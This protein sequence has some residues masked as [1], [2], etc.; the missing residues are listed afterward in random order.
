LLPVS[1]D[2]DSNDFD[3]IAASLRADMTDLDA[4]FE[5]LAAKLE[6]AVPQAVRITRAKLGFRGPKVV[7]AITIMTGPVSLELKRAGAQ[8]QATK[9]RVSGG[10]VLKTEQLDVEE[11]LTELTGALKALAGASERARLALE[12][13][14]LDP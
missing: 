14:L 4:F 1:L 10:I 7:A 11:W 13:V 12:R 3:L 5:G 8:L 2:D 9:A 6:A